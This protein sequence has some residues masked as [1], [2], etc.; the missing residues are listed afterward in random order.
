MQQVEAARHEGVAIDRG[1]YMQG[2][3]IIAAPVLQD[4]CMIGSLV[5]IC[6]NEQLSSKQI[7]QLKQRLREAAARL[8]T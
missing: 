1:N 6:A 3:T 2:Y 8:A 4:R 5:G 7:D